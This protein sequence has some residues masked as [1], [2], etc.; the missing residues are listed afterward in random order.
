MNPELPSYFERRFRE[1]EKNDAESERNRKLNRETFN[2]WGRYLLWQEY[3]QEKLKALG[4]SD[5]GKRQEYKLVAHT[6]L[7][8]V[9][10]LLEASTSERWT[11]RTAF[12]TALVYNFCSRVSEIPLSPRNMEIWRNFLSE[13]LGFEAEDIDVYLKQDSAEASERFEP[14]AATTAK[15][16]ETREAA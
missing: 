4:D 11:D 1:D 10:E 2:Y 5:S 14:A 12:E 15:N 13:R 7:P 3:Y 8:M 9:K 6:I 16:R